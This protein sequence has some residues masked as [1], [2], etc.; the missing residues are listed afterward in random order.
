MLTASSPLTCVNCG[1]KSRSLELGRCKACREAI[2]KEQN[3]AKAKTAIA[4]LLNRDDVL[5]LDTETN[6]I[7]KSSEVIEV[8]VINTK[9]DVLLDTLLKPK[10]MTMNPFAERVHGISLDMVHG[11]PSWLEVFPQ[12]RALADRRTL[13]AWNASFDAGVLEQ[14]S[15][16]WEIQHPRW[17]FVCAM[18]LY[19]KK[20][21]IKLRGLHKSVVDEGLGELLN[22]YQSHRA[23]GDVRFVLEVLK[24]TSARD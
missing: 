16:I 19:A 22:V 1:K 24:A 3:R 20:R 6:G 11:A 13:L 17:L 14:T 9:G 15:N 5:I 2:F 21:G 23:L 18:R 8:S 4:S 12:L 7:G 10:V